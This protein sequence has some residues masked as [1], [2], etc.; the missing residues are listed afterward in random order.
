MQLSPGNR[1]LWLN[2][3]DEREYKAQVLQVR[4]LK[5]QI[6]LTTFDKVWADIESLKLEKLPWR[7]IGDSQKS[8]ITV[9]DRVTVL[10]SSGTVERINHDGDLGVALDEGSFVYPQPSVIE[11][12]TRS[13]P[14]S[15]I[16]PSVIEP[17]TRSQ[18]ESSITLG[19]Y[20]RRKGDR[21]YEYWRLSWR[22]GDRIKHRHVPSA[23]LNQVRD[24]IL[25]GKSRS[26][27]LLL[28]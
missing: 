6:L 21:D 9:G 4:K 3:Q 16:T 25:A 27:L 24:A 26:D 23:K 11:P 20:I 8:S 1:V 2:P 7:T 13:Q 14:E 22:E 5:A 18:P 28:V 15:S 10:G 19:T 17:Q 12:Q